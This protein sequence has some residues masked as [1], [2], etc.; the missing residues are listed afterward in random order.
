MTRSHFRFFALAVG[1]LVCA[2][3]SFRIWQLWTQPPGDVWTP[4]HLA[5]PLQ[6]EATRFEV[7][8]AGEPL[9]RAVE[10]R[11]VQVT[12]VGK[13]EPVTL[14]EVLVRANNHDRAVLELVPKL[15]AL[16]AVAGGALVLFLIGLFTPMIG[17]F[18]QH[19]LVDIHLPT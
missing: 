11:R 18:R 4:A 14:T 3:A 16:S 7:L 5:L 2:V 12:P 9:A 10:Q 6:T 17:A 13:T 8:V 19:G 15:L 1:L